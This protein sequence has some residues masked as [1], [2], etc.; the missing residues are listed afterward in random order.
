MGTIAENLLALQ[1]AKENIKSAIEGKGQD[2]TDVPFTEY[3]DKISAIQT[4]GGIDKMQYKC[5]NIKSL[6]YEF[7][8]QDGYTPKMTNEIVVETMK[9]VDTSKVESM[10]Y[11]FA[12]SS[13]GGDLTDLS[14]IT[15]DA[16]SCTDMQ[17]MF[18]YRVNLTKLPKLI[19]AKPLEIRAMCRDCRYITDP[20]PMDTSD[21][22]A[23]DQLYYGC[24]DLKTTYN[25]DLSNATSVSSMYMSCHDLSSEIEMTFQKTG[26]NMYYTFY[27][28]K[29][30]PKITI[31]NSE[32]VKNFNSAFYSCETLTELSL[33]LINATNIST[34]LSGTKNMTNLDLK[35][36]KLSLAI[37]VGPSW[38]YLLTDESIVNTFKEL[39]DLTGSTSQ[40]LTLSTA[41]NA[42]T[43]QIY[44]KLIDVTDEMRAEDEYID[45]KKPCVVCE[46]TDEGAMTLKA[47]GISKNWNI[48]K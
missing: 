18:F 45:N 38:G 48:A 12:A 47:Y 9:G 40:T 21:V 46:S 19:N 22:T 44:V 2:L 29:H 31:H 23:F 33:N 35:N 26:V 5:D 4:G 20:V 28:C 36:I 43:Q 10:R 24:Y 30:V 17:N 14:E 32:N 3:H 6:A 39:W 25:Y 34:M 42:R 1:T 37:G 7:Y 13:S 11:M 8:Y 16:S 27:L 15:I 41:S